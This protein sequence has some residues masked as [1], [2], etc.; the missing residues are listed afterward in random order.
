MLLEEPPSH[1]VPQ[2]LDASWESRPQTVTASSA[3][4]ESQADATGLYTT[5]THARTNH[6]FALTYAFKDT[7]P[8]KLCNTLVLTYKKQS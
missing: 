2:R 3:A 4:I 7:I 1:N 5:V 6:S 8:Y